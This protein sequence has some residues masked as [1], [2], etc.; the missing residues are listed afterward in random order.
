M[1]RSSS[2]PHPLESHR[3]QV[4]A[5]IATVRRRQTLR[6]G[7]CA[8]E[9]AEERRCLGF[10]GQF[11]PVETDE[12]VARGESRR[13]PGPAASCHTARRRH[14]RTRRPR[15]RRGV[16]RRSSQ[17]PR[18]GQRPGPRRRPAPWRRRSRSSPRRAAASVVAL[19][20]HELAVCVLQ[21]EHHGGALVVV[22]VAPEMREA[23]AGGSGRRG[24]DAV[25]LQVGAGAHGQRCGDRHGDA[26]QAPQA[27]ALIRVVLHGFRLRARRNERTLRA[28]KSRSAARVS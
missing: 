7:A 24:G 4:G 25:A 13:Q 15:G 27:G 1:A 8:G 20:R 18:R 23:H 14:T 12:H 5:P 2:A 17:R 9:V 6:P 28:C 16:P 21:R 11:V 10:G 22:L 26:P 19:R 3:L